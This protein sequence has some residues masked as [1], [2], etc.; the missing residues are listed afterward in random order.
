MNKKGKCI[1]VFADMNQIRDC[2]TD[3]KRLDNSVEYLVKLLNLMGNE[4]RFKILYSIFNEKELC[5]CDL[6]DILGMNVSAI[7]Q[8]LRKLKDGRIVEDRKTGQTIFYSIKKGKLNLIKKIF[9]CIPDDK[10]MINLNIA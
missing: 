6:S 8:H 3:L 1:R 10:Q 2:R 5:V 4:V 9:T 7:S